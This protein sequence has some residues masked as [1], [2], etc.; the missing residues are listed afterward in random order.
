MG[1]G[2]EEGDPPADGWIKEKKKE[3]EYREREG[4]DTSSV[5]SSAPSDLDQEHCG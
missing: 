4:R 2:S 3:R 1:G 5:E